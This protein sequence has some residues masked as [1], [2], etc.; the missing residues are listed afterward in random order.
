MAYANDPEAI[1]RKFQYRKRILQK[2][3]QIPIGKAKKLV[4]P[5]CA[6]H[7]YRHLKGGEEA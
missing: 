2:E 3:L 1:R 5:D 7:I 4:G 6:Y